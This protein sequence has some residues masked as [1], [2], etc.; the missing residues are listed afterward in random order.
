MEVLTGGQCQQF[1]GDLTPALY[2][3]G[4]DAG[5]LANLGFANPTG[6]THYLAI[7][8]LKIQVVPEDSTLWSCRGLLGRA[9]DSK[10][11]SSLYV[12]EI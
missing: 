2:V 8:M 1:P 6:D 9:I 3:S 7:L 10:K 11:H 12:Y 5:S 4:H